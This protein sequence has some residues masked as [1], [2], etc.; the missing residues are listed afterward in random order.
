LAQQL[1]FR[2]TPAGDLASYISRFFDTRIGAKTESGSYTTIAEMLGRHANE[3]LFVSDAIK[4]IDAARAAS[5][6]AL[7]CVREG[8]N[9]EPET[10]DR[11]VTTFDPILPDR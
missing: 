2:S 6:Q 11:F 3:M 10:G 7:L 9:P 4:E 5:M 8:K 1:L